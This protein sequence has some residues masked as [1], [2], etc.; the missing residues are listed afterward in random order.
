MT[1]W[2]TLLPQWCYWDLFIHPVLESY[3]TTFLSPTSYLL[4][5]HFPLCLS[6]TLE[7]GKNQVNVF[8]IFPS[9]L[10]YLAHKQNTKLIIRVLFSPMQSIS[11]HPFNAII[12]EFVRQTF[13][14]VWFS[15]GI[16]HCFPVD[17]FTVEHLQ[18]IC[19][20]NLALSG[21]FH[22]VVM[23][24]Y[25][26]GGGELKI[27]LNLLPVGKKVGRIVIFRRNEWKVGMARKM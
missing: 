22:S 11:L 5:I 15:P 27:T 13:N 23:G 26:G 9:I 12:V 10:L 4:A 8:N 3:W 7:K 6:R 18:S 16:G 2:E 19:V 17:I 21:N 24:D 25:G 14:L 1:A 20:T